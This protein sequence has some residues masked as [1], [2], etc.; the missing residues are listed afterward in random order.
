MVDAK[1]EGWIEIA[2]RGFE[3]WK[4][5]PHNARW[6]RKIDG[7]PIPN[8]LTICIG[9]AF[10]EPLRSLSSRVEAEKR[11][12]EE[13]E[14]KARASVAH[15]VESLNEQMCNY[16]SRTLAA[17]RERDGWKEAYRRTGGCM[18]C[19]IT[20]PAPYGCTDCLNTGWERGAPTGYVETSALE[21]AETHSAA[22]ARA[23]KEAERFMAYFAGEADGVFVG[24]GTPKSCLE[25]IRRARSL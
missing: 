21:A 13:A 24:P 10:A 19:A 1:T 22:L 18:S 8:D 3:N 23:L 6:F 12:R 11:A 4:A 20:S 16:A 15:V 5:K 25:V 17:E 14:A 9:E 2:Q 7:T